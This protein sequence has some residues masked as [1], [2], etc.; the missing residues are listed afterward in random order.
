MKFKLFM[1][2]LSPLFWQLERVEEGVVVGVV[3][4][5]VVEDGFAVVEAVAVEFIDIKQRNP[6][7]PNSL[8]NVDVTLIDRW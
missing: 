8:W 5:F 7:A 1:I 6:Y 2:K 3:V 4:G